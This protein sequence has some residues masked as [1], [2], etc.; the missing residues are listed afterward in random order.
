MSNKLREQILAIRD[1]GVVNMFDIS[2][3]KQEAQKRG[4]T[5]LLLFL[6]MQ[7]D[8]YLEFITKGES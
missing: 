2:G 8:K 6:D 7:K 4:Y 1:S 5:L 3:V